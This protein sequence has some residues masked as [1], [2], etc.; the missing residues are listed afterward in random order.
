MVTPKT[1]NK[2]FQH[3]AA[4]CARLFRTV[5]Q[6]DG[7]LFEEFQAERM[8]TP[9]TM[10]KEFQHLAALCARLVG[11]GAIPVNYAV[12]V[13]LPKADGVSTLPFREAEA[14]ALLAA[15]DRLGETNNV[16]GG[17]TSY[18]A[19]RI[20]EERRYARA[21]VLVL[22]TTGLRISDAVNLERSKV[23]L[24]RK[25]VTRL[26]I[27]TEKTGVVVTLALPNATV[28]ALKKLPSVGHDLYFWAGGDEA[29]LATACDRA[30]RVIA[31]LG[32]I[33][34]VKDAR[35]HRFRDTWAK[36]ALL[37]GTSMRTVQLV[38]GHKSIRTTERHY[39]PYVP[40]YQAMIDEATAAVAERLIS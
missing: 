29:R 28:N 22:L 31:R 14:K 12:Q 23:Y 7:R 24:D 4:L 2:E 38:L 40:E 13:K 9:K 34:K 16:R 25:G 36:E 18:S 19:D 3:L 20:D 26:K 6:F 21:L 27:R 1:M 11:L 8:V 35:P 33:A 30:R 5:E 39:A 17:Y 15:C 10:N 37:H 32:A